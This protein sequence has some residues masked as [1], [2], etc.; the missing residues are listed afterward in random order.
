ML[1]LTAAVR[2]HPQVLEPSTAFPPENSGITARGDTDDVGFGT[3]WSLKAFPLDGGHLTGVEQ[4]VSSTSGSVENG[5]GV[6]IEINHPGLLLSDESSNRSG[7][8]N[9]ISQSNACDQRSNSLKSRRLRNRNPGQKLPSSCPANPIGR[10]PPAEQQIK[11]DN[12]PLGT[13]NW[14]PNEGK[15]IPVDVPEFIF[16]TKGKDYTGTSTIPKMNSEICPPERLYPMCADD[17]AIQA[18]PEG[19]EHLF[20]EVRYMLNPAYACTSPC[21]ISCSY[22]RRDKK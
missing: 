1:I 19:I 18:V 4:F 10:N 21:W 22:H 5:N 3:L 11:P 13:D 12:D 17:K 9:I 7:E 16:P 20:T 2:P 14:E 6:E 15:N 8:E